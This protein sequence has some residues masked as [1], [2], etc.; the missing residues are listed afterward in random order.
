VVRLVA[1]LP[2]D[3]AVPSTPDWN[4]LQLLAH[5]AGAGV[6]LATD[7]CAGW[8]WPD[9]TAGHVSRRSG[10]S[11]AEVLAEWAGAVEAAA[12]RVDHPEAYGL[13]EA[14]TRMPV[15]D[16]VGHEHDIAE[17]AGVTAC[18]E[19]DDWAVVG[20]HRHAKLDE[21]LTVFGVPALRV[22]TPEGDDWTV[23]GDHPQCEV[24]LPRHELWR[25]LT[26]RRTRRAVSGYDWSCDPAPYVAVWVG[27]TF[28]WPAGDT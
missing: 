23:G 6:D 1:D 4:L 20:M 14:F 13:G 18:I 2:D 24:V 5:L 11:R 21:N 16:A 8:S 15:I 28:S 10:C 22:R 3:M 19:A 17:A 27:G 26:G 25:S 7:N 12:L 9:W